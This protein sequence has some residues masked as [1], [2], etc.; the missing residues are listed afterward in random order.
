MREVQIDIGKNIAATA[1]ASGAA[2]FSVQNID[3][4]M[5]YDAN[6]LSLD[7][8]VR[9]TRPGYE[10]ALA[11]TF[12]LTMYADKRINN[13]LSV[14]TAA[15]QVSTRAIKT[16]VA[17]QE[18]VRK[19]ILQF[20]KGKWQRYINRLCP[21]V[22]GRSSILDEKGEVAQIGACALDPDYQ[23]SDQEWA[24]LMPSVQNYE[25]VG[26]GVLAKLTVSYNDFGRGLD[27]SIDLDFDD[28]DLKIKRERE[29]LSQ[30]LTQG[31]AKGWKS[32]EKHLEYVAEM[33]SRVSILEK[34]ALARGD[35]IIPRQ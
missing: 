13:N 3:G 12:S 29:N 11:P 7:V 24:Q 30:E 15:L 28:L 20:K 21:A 18:F 6:R 26:D 23:L 33:K 16:H 17:A 1:K 22:T 31:D 32:T 10:I 27:Y 8:P 14:H 19:V 35:S 25:W 9:Y 34:N 5:M 2:G 4:L